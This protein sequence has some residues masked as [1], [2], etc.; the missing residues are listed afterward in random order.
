MVSRATQGP[1]A[2]HSRSARGL[3]PT[4]AWTLGGGTVVL[5]LF[6]MLYVLGVSLGAW[7]AGTPQQAIPRLAAAPMYQEFTALFLASALFI[8]LARE[9]GVRTR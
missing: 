3:K 5:A 9:F 7:W 1:P 4:L 6:V 8:Y 2:Q